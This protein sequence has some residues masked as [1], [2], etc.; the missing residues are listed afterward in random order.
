MT[1]SLFWS[2]YTLELQEQHIRDV[3]ALYRYLIAREKWNWF[4][5]KIPEQEQVKILRGH[6]HGD[7][8]WSCRKWLNH[9]LEWIRENKP[10]AVYDAV[11]DKIHIMDIKPVEELEKQAAR[12]ISSEELK[13]LQKAG[14]FRC[15]REDKK[16][17]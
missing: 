2:R 4:L 12:N 15:I 11:I 3:D 1:L 16:T 6:N 17:E 8:A 10:A 5:A 7:G 14:Y 13:N 9:M